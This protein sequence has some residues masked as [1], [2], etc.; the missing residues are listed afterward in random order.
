MGSARLYTFPVRQTCVAASTASGV[1]RFSVPRSSSSPQ[2]PQFRPVMAASIRRVGPH[3][4]FGAVT[5]A[6]P[7]R[8]SGPTLR[9]ERKFWDAGDQVVC[10][11]DEVGRGAWAGPVTVAAVVPA[12]EHVRGVRDSKQLT[13]AEREK[14]ARAVRRWAV[15]IGVGHASHEECDELGMTAALRTAA[16]RALAELDAQGYT[17]DRIVLDGNHDYL[18]HGVAGHH[19]DQG[20]REVPGGGGGVVRGQGDARRA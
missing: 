14:A 13:R 17:P 1:S 6:A 2:R 9:L 18:R 19:R 12:P 4:R 8:R 20:R 3:T 10:G 16:L 15:A 11:I 5:A 7:T